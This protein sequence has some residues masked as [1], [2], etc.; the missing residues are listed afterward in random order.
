MK[1]KLFR[2]KYEPRKILK[3]FK[4]VKSLTDQQY[5]A[6]CSVEGIIKKFG[7]LPQ[8][9][10]TPLHCDVSEYGDF[11]EALMRVENAKAEFM[12]LPSEI[13]QRF[14]NDPKVFFDFVTNSAN[15]E[16]LVRMG[17]AHKREVPKTTEELLTD[18]NE[19]LKKG[20][21]SNEGGQS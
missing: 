16:E 17:L 8:P 2:T 13:R 7:I 18:I 10:A 12:S 3:S 11:N 6:E 15:L 1:S 20:V 4:G 5:K 14:G 21:T 9:T 19:T